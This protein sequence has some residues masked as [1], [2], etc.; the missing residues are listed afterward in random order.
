[1]WNIGCICVYVFMFLCICEYVYGYVYLCI[2][3]YVDMW[4]C[5]YVYLWI[6]LCICICGYV[7]VYVFMW[8]STGSRS[9]LL[10]FL[11]SLH[12]SICFFA[13]SFFHLL[14]PPCY[15]MFTSPASS[16]RPLFR[17]IIDFMLTELFHVY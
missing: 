16:F 10:H 15:F 4:I 6:C 9:T 5:V 13:N 11:L 1:M 8:I 14:H 2:C 12:F 17:C 3:V 7:C